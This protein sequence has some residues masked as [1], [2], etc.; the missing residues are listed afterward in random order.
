MVELSRRRMREHIK[1]YNLGKWPKAS[2]GKCNEDGA[3]CLIKDTFGLVHVV[4]CE[5]VIYSGKQE[6]SIDYDWIEASI[7][8]AKS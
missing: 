2:L 1:E 8:T 5:H 7:P 4:S 3:N 6:P